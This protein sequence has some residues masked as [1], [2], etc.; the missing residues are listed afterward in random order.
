MYF[1][2]GFVISMEVAYDCWCRFG[3]PNIVAWRPCVQSVMSFSPQQRLQND[4]L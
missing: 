3:P 4:A 2:S 1:I